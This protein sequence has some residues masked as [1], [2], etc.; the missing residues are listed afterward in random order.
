MSCQSTDQ[1]GS[2]DLVAQ[3]APCAPVMLPGLDKGCNP[4]HMNNYSNYKRN[5]LNL[6]K[7]AAWCF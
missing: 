4:N 7:V 5:E 3:V 6:N 2:P 1:V